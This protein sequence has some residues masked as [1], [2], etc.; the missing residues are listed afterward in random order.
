MVLSGLLD[1]RVDEEQPEDVEDE[2]EV[3]DER[4]TGQ[5]EQPAQHERD[6][7]ANHQHFLL[8]LPRYGEPRHDDD[9]HEQV[10]DAEAVFRHPAG[11]EFGG[12][13]DRS[14]P[15]HEQRE[16]QREPDV[17]AHPDRRFLRRRHVWPAIGEDQVEREDR[18]Q[19]HI[20][21]DLEPDGKG[22]FHV[23]PFRGGLVGG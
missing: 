13:V 23:L 18:E 7:D 3:L 1:R 16:H 20:G 12:A 9:E 17:N 14:L 8:V 11:D 21:G 19:H 4:G 10:V 15:E 2:T 22:G 6:Q 5:D